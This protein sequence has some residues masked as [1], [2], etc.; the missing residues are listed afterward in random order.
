MADRPKIPNMGDPVKKGPEPEQVKKQNQEKAIRLACFTAA[1][2]VLFFIAPLI[3]NQ[4]SETVRANGLVMLMLIV[5]QVFIAVVGWQSN[6]FPKYGI[7][8]PIAYIVLYAVSELV[9]YGQI[10][11]GMEVNYMQTGY[12]AYFLNKFLTRKR[13]LDAKKKNKPFPKG[14]S[15]R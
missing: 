2:A 1:A 4:M 5:N 9:F 12:I 15:R 13:M 14:I 6:R 3:L 7:Y 8:I 10:G 11:W